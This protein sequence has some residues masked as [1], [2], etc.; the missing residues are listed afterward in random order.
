VK[1]EAKAFTTT[2]EEWISSS[3]ICGVLNLS[4][5]LSEERKVPDGHAAVPVVVRVFVMDQFVG[6][7]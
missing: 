4:G 3:G 1:L 7:E 2:A 6:K 5:E